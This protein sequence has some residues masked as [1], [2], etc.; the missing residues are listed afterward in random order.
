[1]VNALCQKSANDAAN[2]ICTLPRHPAKGFH[3]RIATALNFRPMNIQ[4]VC[5][6]VLAQPFSLPLLTESPPHS[7]DRCHP[8]SSTLAVPTLVHTVLILACWLRLQDFLRGL[9]TYPL[10][11]ANSQV[12]GSPRFPNGLLT[13][14]NRLHHLLAHS[15]NGCRH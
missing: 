10:F 1:M 14:C 12:F 8:I 13:P 9:P 2:T 5:P 3:T 15:A 6:W 7:L 4:Q 11:V